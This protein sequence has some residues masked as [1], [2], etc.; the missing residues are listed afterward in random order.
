[1][2]DQVK[3]GRGKSSKTPYVLVSVRLDADVHEAWKSV[4]P[5]KYQRMVRQVLREHLIN[6]GVLPNENS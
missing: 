4:Y 5:S 3:R 2:N 6:K 1:M